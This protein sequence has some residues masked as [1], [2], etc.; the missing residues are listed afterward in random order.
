TLLASLPPGYIQQRLGMPADTNPAKV[1]QAMRDQLAA[2][3]IRDAATYQS[4]ADASGGIRKLASD[5]RDAEGT[6]GDSGD[7]MPYLAASAFGLLITVVGADGRPDRMG[8]KT[9][10]PVTMVH[11]TYERLHWLAALP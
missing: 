10:R 9:G 4:I 8:N 2:Q 3:L 1:V 11:I 7:L 6:L 5:L